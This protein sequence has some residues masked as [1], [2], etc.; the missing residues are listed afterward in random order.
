MPTQ[1][2]IVAVFALARAPATRWGTRSFT[3]SSALDHLPGLE[4][5]TRLGP[6]GPLETWYVGPAEIL[7]H[8][9]ETAHYRDNL[10]AAR[11][12]LWV[13]LEPGAPRL[14]AAS[15]DPYEGEAMAGDDG[16]LVGAVDMPPGLRA[17]VAAFHAAHHVERPFEKRRRRAAD[18]EALARRGPFPG[19]QGRPGVDPDARGGRP[20]GPD[21]AGPQDGG[22]QDWNGPARP[23]RDAP[24]KP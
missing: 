20:A 2:L 11:P 9:G 6:E 16:R 10:T 22:A 23:P 17:A 13:A 21:R 14:T 3:P 8:S 15:V 12:S 18:P 19:A 7:L 24:E 4:P 5:A 1:T